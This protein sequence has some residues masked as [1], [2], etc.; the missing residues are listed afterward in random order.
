M[1]ADAPSTPADVVVR[2]LS[3]ADRAA[4]APLA[5]AALRGTPYLGRAREILDAALAND[6]E[7]T[8]I[9]AF[10]SLDASA[11]AVALFGPV[12]GAH[13]AWRLGALLFA[14][15]A[16]RRETADPLIGRA[17][18]MVR[19]AGGR[20]LMAELPAD[21]AVGFSLTALRANGFKQE[22]RVTDFYRDGVAQL[23][24]RLDFTAGAGR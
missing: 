7:W 14:P 2:E 18:E 19:A 21:E 5:L 20:F 17:S 11:R 6:P 16:R 12:A 10:D 24:L 3:A 13:D 1:T 9:G 22:A 15:D 4:A 23:F 8:A